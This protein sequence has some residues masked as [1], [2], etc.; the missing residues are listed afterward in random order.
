MISGEGSADRRERE[1]R[2]DLSS[3]T[4]RFADGRRGAET[5]SGASSRASSAAAALWFPPT[6]FLVVVEEALVGGRLGGE[7]D[8]CGVLD[9][10]SR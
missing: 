4:V 10:E 1:A 7:E 6:A 5:F 3:L 2:A 8:A 9:L